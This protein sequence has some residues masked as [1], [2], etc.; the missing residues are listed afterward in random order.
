MIYI[1]DNFA[2]DERLDCI[3]PFTCTEYD[4]ELKIEVYEQIKD[5]AVE[6]ITLYYN[7][8]F[9][10]E[11]LNF[12]DIK[13]SPKLD[14]WGYK[15]NTN[16]LTNLGYAYI[17]DNL[18]MIHVDKIRSD[19]QRVTDEDGFENITAIDI[20]KYV[21]QSDTYGELINYATV[22]KGKLLS[23][24]AE[25]SH[26]LDKDET[27]IGVET[28]V[29]YHGNGYAVSNVAALARQM[30]EEG[31]RVWYKCGINNTASQKT[32]M[33]AGFRCAGK[34]YYYVAYKKED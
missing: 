11:A 16:I 21:D 18:S 4:N 34:Y 31:K 10:D 3:I 9:S 30:T 32:A 29:G 26:Y 8:P 23:V 28:A 24:A 22:S 5:I 17:I 25:N 33:S 27:E 7:S 15:R 1:E 6:F 2:L 19:T 12:I 13:I 14:E 20:N